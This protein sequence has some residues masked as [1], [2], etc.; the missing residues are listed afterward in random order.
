MYHGLEFNKDRR[1]SVNNMKYLKKYPSLSVRTSNRV[2]G[3]NYLVSLKRL[4]QLKK[5]DIAIK[6]YLIMEN[7]A[8]RL[9]YESLGAEKK[10][11]VEPPSTKRFLG[12]QPSPKF[13]SDY[14]N[15]KEAEYYAQY[16]K[17]YGSHNI[18]DTNDDFRNE[19]LFINY[20]NFENHI[21]I[22]HSLKKVLGFTKD[23]KNNNTF[24]ENVELYKGFKSPKVTHKKPEVDL[25]QIKLVVFSKK[26]EISSCYNIFLTYN[27]GLKGEM[28]WQWSINMSGQTEQIKL[29]RSDINNLNFINCIKNRISRWTFPKPKKGKVSIRYPFKFVPINK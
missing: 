13:Y 20:Q 15:Y 26:D 6:T 3:S 9:F 17:K 10:G 27:P 2:Y 21:I 24:W 1:S 8:L 28:V 14:K 18:D 11:I 4:E 22:P 19:T 7:K 12:A 29:I 23:T 25:S 16:S 5:S